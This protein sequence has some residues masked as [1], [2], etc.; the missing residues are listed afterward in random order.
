MEISPVM[1]VFGFQKKANIIKT[2]IKYIFLLITVSIN[3]FLELK[4]FDMK[5][6]L[7]RKKYSKIE[8][9]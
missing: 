2:K 1:T 6:F 7:R 8:K 9:V 3:I 5:L 4:I